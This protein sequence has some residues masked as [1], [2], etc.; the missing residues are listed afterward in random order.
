MEFTVLEDQRTPS[1]EVLSFSTST[2]QASLLAAKLTFHLQSSCP[3]SVPLES[4][5]LQKHL[6]KAKAETFSSN[7]AGQ[8]SEWGSTTHPDIEITIN[9]HIY[10]INEKV[11][12]TLFICVFY[13]ATFALNND[14][15]A[16]YRLEF[17]S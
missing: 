10:L 14:I 7:T 5:F 1:C 2:S 13:S 11:N 9:D 6:E 15:H 4:E 3:T 16:S 17:E 8:H 12:T